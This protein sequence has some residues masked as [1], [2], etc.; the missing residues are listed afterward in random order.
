VTRKS[1]VLEAPPS[2][3]GVPIHLPPVWIDSAFQ[4][5]FA[6]PLE[7]AFVERSKHVIGAVSGAGKT[8]ALHALLRRH[9]IVKFPD[10]Q[11]SAPVVPTIS[12]EADEQSR[13]ALVRRVI[14][15]IGVPPAM[16]VG[17]LE[18]WMLAQL[19][20]CDTR[21][22]V[23]DDSQD[24]GLSVLKQI[25]KIIDRLQ[26][27]FGREIGVCFLVASEGEAIPL[28]DLL[29]GTANDTYRQF[30]RRFSHEQPW[31]YVPALAE[32]ELGEVLSG[33]EMVL[34]DV[35]PGMQVERWAPRIHRHLRTAYFDPYATGRVTMQNVQNLVLSVAQRLAARG[36]SKVTAALIDEVAEAL[37]SGVRVST[38]TEEWQAPE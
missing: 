4:R 32:D 8:T 25:K 19:H 17:A 15:P 20:Q 18:D 28:R 21:L 33:L 30:R 7:R 3:S 36:D 37:Q 26:L 6:T 10:G 2:A 29:V 16:T 27:E 24:F 13:S 23:F 31:I 12:T 35:V 9:P 34:A 5:R 14:K 38:A 1:A 22:L 11:T